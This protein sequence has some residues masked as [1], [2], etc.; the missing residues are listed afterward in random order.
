VSVSLCVSVCRVCLTRLC[1]SVSVSMPVGMAGCFLCVLGVSCVSDASVCVC[2]C[3]FSVS[4]GL[5]AIFPFQLLLVV[6][7][8]QTSTHRGIARYICAF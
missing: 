8:R 3:L 6:P 5:C 4:V 1:L 2:L 7:P